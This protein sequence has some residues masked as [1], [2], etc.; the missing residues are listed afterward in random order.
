MRHYKQGC[1]TT[2]R[3]KELVLITIFANIP[4]ALLGAELRNIIYKSLFQRI[5]N[6]VYIQENAEFIDAKCIEIGDIVNILKGV[7]ID[8][9]TNNQTKFNFRI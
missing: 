6:L 5:G 9:N 7:R 2:Q 4:T 1:F 3:L 8:A